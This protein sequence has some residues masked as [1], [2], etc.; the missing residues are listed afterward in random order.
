MLPLTVLHR[1]PST[2]YYSRD[3]VHA[4]RVVKPGT[5]LTMLKFVE[6]YSMEDDNTILI[7]ILHYV[8][9]GSRIK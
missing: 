5:L 1:D 8:K 9:T 3:T 2:S 7:P 4:C 6:L